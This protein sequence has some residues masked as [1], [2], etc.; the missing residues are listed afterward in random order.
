MKVD[1]CHN[2]DIL[3]KDNFVI[4]L[5]SRQVQTDRQGGGIRDHSCLCLMPRNARGQAGAEVDTTS[6]RF[7]LLP[8]LTMALQHLTYI[9]KIY[10]V[11]IPERGCFSSAY[12]YAG[13][14]VKST[15]FQR[16][17]FFAVLLYWIALD[18]RHDNDICVK[19]HFFQRRRYPSVWLTLCNTSSVSTVV[20]TYI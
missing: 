16:L 12:V 19:I 14:Q 15:Y 11:F 9:V 10:K 3:R 20:L 7:A 4:W 5:V 17:L 13:I 6:R 18:C 2:V 1:A 8:S